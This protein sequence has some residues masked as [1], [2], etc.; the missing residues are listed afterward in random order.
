ML[1]ITWDTCLG[2]DYGWRFLGEFKDHKSTV[3]RVWIR[4]W[5]EFN[6]AKSKLLGVGI[7]E[8]FMQAP[9]NYLRCNREKVP[10]KFLQ[11]Y[12]GCNP[13]R[14]DVWEPVINVF[15]KNLA[16]CK[17]RHLSIGGNVTLMNPVLCNLTIYHLYFYK[18]HVKVQQAI[19]SL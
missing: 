6:I 18:I 8:K 1:G 15:K 11:I 14:G 10:C 2:F 19:V 16:K 12:V 5:Y 4:I 9:G 13:W 3:K 7:R 17:E